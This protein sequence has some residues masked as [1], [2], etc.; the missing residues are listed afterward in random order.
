MRE[1]MQLG[2]FLRHPNHNASGCHLEGVANV[3]L[4]AIAQLQW[5]GKSQANSG[6]KKMLEG[7]CTLA[8]HHGVQLFCSTNQFFFG[9][10]ILRIGVGQ[11]PFRV[12]RII[13]ITFF[14]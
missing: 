12:K 6:V 11:A 13:I 1:Q 4:S 10:V 7:G 3:V 14:F 9:R 5:S 2:S 8:D